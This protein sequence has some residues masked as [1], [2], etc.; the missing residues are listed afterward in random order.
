MA[1]SL[2]DDFIVI[3]EK[4][5][6]AEFLGVPVCTVAP[7]SSCTAFPDT[8]FHH[9]EGNYELEAVVQECRPDYG[10]SDS[11][12]EEIV[13]PR[14][15][16]SPYKKPK[17]RKKKK[18]DS[19]SELS[20]H[21]LD[22][23]R[24]R[25]LSIV[26]RPWF[27]EFR[28]RSLL[29]GEKRTL[30]QHRRR[31][32]R[33]VLARRERLRVAGESAYTLDEALSAVATNLKALG[34]TDIN[35]MFAEYY[36]TVL[37]KKKGAFRRASAALDELLNPPV[38]EEPPSPPKEEPSKKGRRAAKPPPVVVPVKKKKKKKRINFRDDA[39]ADT[40]ATHEPCTPQ[41]VHEREVRR[42]TRRRDSCK[43]KLDELV[44]RHEALRQQLR[45]ATQD[46]LQ[47]LKSLEE[48]RKGVDQERLRVEDEYRRDAR[49]LQVITK[50]L[51]EVK[52]KMRSHD[53]PSVDERAIKM[54]MLIDG[55]DDI[56]PSFASDSLA[57]PDALS[58]SSE[59]HKHGARTGEVTDAP[60][61]KRGSFS[62]LEDAHE[63]GEDEES[64][65]ESSDEENVLAQLERLRA[66]RE[67]ARA[68]VE[69]ALEA[70]RARLR[71]AAE[72]NSGPVELEQ[73]YEEALQLL[74]VEERIARAQREREEA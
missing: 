25:D 33:D 55:E 16:G 53:R 43:V 1:A 26:P 47:V 35:T 18:L 57:S 49:R 74:F 65:S 66:D 39:S 50:E 3:H 30:E 54:G 6:V 70:E 42:A 41:E 59:W 31:A 56:L 40:V 67:D 71:A 60:G 61:L 46:Q 19:D 12:E 5:P 32:Q 72:A 23:S 37:A 38:E 51:R 14:V 73:K 17:R 64:V 29:A 45:S 48:R 28:L 24:E 2:R 9:T 21:P 58:R 34:R 52:S 20:P 13:L 8:M 69:H 4:P 27:D 22:P 63:S 36:P 44:A 62:S 15:R 7:R 10:D 11:D 68:A